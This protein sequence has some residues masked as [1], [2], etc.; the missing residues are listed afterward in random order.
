MTFIINED[1][2][3]TKRSKMT[4]SRALRIFEA[5]KGICVLSGLRIGP[6]DDWFIEHI[7]ALELGGKDEE[8]NM[9]PALY[10]RKAKKDAAD[11]SAAAKSKRIKQRHLGIRK[12]S[13][14]PASRDSRWKKKLNGEVV[15]REP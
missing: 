14:F 6:R 13:R 2:G 4:P 12:P 9:G 7:I 8:S 1:V 15:R 5:H 10:V 3:T 11:H